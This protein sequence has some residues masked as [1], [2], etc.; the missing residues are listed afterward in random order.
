[1]RRMTLVA[2]VAVTALAAL[3]AGAADSAGVKASAQ[4]KTQAKSPVQKAVFFAADGMRQDI[5]ARVRRAGPHAD[6]VGLPEEGHVAQRQRP[7]DPGA[8]EHRRRLVQPRDRRVAGRPRLHQQ[9]LPHQRRSRSRNRTAAFDPNV[10]QAESI[11]QSAERGGLKVA[12]VEWAGGR[13]A[14]IHGP[15]IDFQSFFSGRG[16]ATNFIGNAGDA[17]LRRRRVHRRVRAAVRPSGR[18]RRP[19]RRSPAPP[20]RRPP[21]GP[22]VPDVVQPG[23]GDAPARARLRRRQVRAER[24]HL[25]QHERRRRRTTTR[26]SSRRRRTAPTPSARSAK[27]EWADV[28]VKIAGGALAGL[29]AGMLVKVEELTPD[30]S[31]VRLFHTSVSRAIASWPTLARRAR[32]HAATSPSTS[33]RSSR[34]RPPPTSRSSRP[35]SRQRGDLRRAGPVLEDRP[36][37]DARVRRQDV[38]AR[39]AAGRHARRRTSSSTSSSASSRR[40]CPAARRTRPTTTST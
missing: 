36:P 5:V 7:A 35:A 11:A 34:P 38:Q 28:K 22:D 23:E 17:A 27:G 1:M 10:L 30:L 32:V 40:S 33:R 4:A 6:H 14:T 39:P 2:V 20:R 31:R 8:A 24:L 13:N 15:T 12:Q 25:R 16:V 9:H 3:A 21:A 29:T 19:G 18:V 37:A 26:C